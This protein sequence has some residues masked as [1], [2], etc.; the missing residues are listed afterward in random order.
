MH[1]FLCELVCV[2]VCVCAWICV[3]MLVCAVV[4]NLWS[5]NVI[6]GWVEKSGSPRVLEW[7]H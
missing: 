2:C 5:C 6:R 3:Y 4:K 1:M 7:L